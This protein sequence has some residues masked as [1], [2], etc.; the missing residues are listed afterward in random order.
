MNVYDLA[1]KLEREIRQLPEYQE[2]QATKQAI[3]E[4]AVANSIFQ[5]FLALQQGFQTAMQTGQMPSEEDQKAMQLVSEK[6]EQ[7][8]LV[9]SYFDQQQR[10][11]V[12]M[13]DIEGIVFKPLQEL[14]N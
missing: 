11:S 3:A 7:N 8:E 5:E 10:L 6:I 9:K 12:Y 2:A 14:F 13:Q 4:D 1:N